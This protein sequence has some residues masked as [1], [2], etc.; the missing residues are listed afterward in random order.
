ML[1]VSIANRERLV[2]DQN[3]GIDVGDHRERESHCHAAGICFDWLV[4]E[5]AVGCDEYSKPHDASDSIER[6]QIFFCGG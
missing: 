6:A 3:I 2:D 4:E 5:I 1:E